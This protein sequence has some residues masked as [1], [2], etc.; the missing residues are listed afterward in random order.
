MQH[1]IFLTPHLYFDFSETLILNKMMDNETDTLKRGRSNSVHS[2]NFLSNTH[3]CLF[4][5]MSHNN[6]FGI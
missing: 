3:M 2:W 1:A 4:T 6:L 5:F